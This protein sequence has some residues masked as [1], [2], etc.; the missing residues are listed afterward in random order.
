MSTF[1]L[2]EARLKDKLIYARQ[3]E[4]PFFL[5]QVDS[6]DTEI[7]VKDGTLFV[8]GEKQTVSFV[9]HF[10]GELAGRQVLFLVSAEN[11]QQEV[12]Q[13]LC[14]QLDLS[15][16]IT[17]DTLSGLYLHAAKTCQYYLKIA[18]AVPSRCLYI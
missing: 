12:L 18:L 7:E 15:V 16:I 8:A 4:T 14:Q 5:E 17:R 10:A 2:L 6:L 11:G 3:S 1:N 13:G 9:K